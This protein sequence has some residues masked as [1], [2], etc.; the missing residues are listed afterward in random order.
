M[1]QTWSEGTV[2]VGWGLTG[3]KAQRGQ[4][5]TGQKEQVVVA[6]THSV[7]RGFTA[8]NLECRV[9]QII[10]FFCFWISQNI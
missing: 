2:I 9:K 10:N 3:H 1:F 5:R 7:Q 4:G 8:S 6:K